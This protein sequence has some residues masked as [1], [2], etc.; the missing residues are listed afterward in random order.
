[1]NATMKS[2]FAM[3]RTAKQCTANPYLP[4]SRWLGTALFATTL[5]CFNV[6]ALLV[7]P[8]E[9]PANAVAAQEVSGVGQGTT[10]SGTD[11]PE[12]PDIAGIGTSAPGEADEPADKRT[13]PNDSAEL[14]EMLSSPDVGERWRAARRLGQLGASAA[15]AVPALVRTLRD[16][17]AG[18]RHNAVIALGSIGVADEEILAALAKAIADPERRVRLSAFSSLRRLTTDPAELVP[19]VSQLLQHQDQIIASRAVETVIQR[20][21]KAVPVLI[22]ALQ[23]ERAAYWAAL[24]VEEIGAPAAETVPALTQLLQS[25]DDNTLKVQILL[26]LASI[27]DAARPAEQPILTILSNQA[28]PSN[29]SATFLNTAAAYA[30]G[31]LRLRSAVEPLQTASRSKDEM[32]SMMA[33]WALAR[34][35]PDSREQTSLAVQRLVQGLASEDPAVRHSAAEGIQTLNL[36]AEIVGPKLIELLRET[37]PVISYNV[38][39]A[40]ASLGPAVAADVAGALDNPELRTLAARVIGQLGKDAAAVVPQ[41][42]DALDSAE[43]EFR[44]TLQMAIAEIGPDA[45]TATPQLIQSLDSDLE[46]VRTTAMLALGKIG[47]AADQSIGALRLT[48]QSSQDA[49]ERIGA[50]WALVRVA[51]DDGQIIEAALPVLISGLQFPDAMVQSEA[52]DTLGRLGESAEAAVEPL[53]QLANDET[54]S[55]SARQAAVRALAKIKS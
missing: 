37:D 26:A 25:T 33:A 40:I 19:I 5:T 27:G 55:I 4:S 32:L 7:A 54:A 39:E 14:A 21:E 2:T 35:E 34:I 24:A 43:G 48:M 38:V 15:P 12:E 50:A 1:M 23:N 3:Q 49:F 42:V 44:K 10:G 13:L 47:P 29:P 28:G 8:G 53:A 16:E 52:A 46:S 17:N 6:D 18:V 20:G 36:S 31:T 51:P 41:V 30:A 9:H 45:A 22:E 11:R